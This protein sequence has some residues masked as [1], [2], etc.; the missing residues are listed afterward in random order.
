MQFWNF[1][2]YFT[3]MEAMLD[4]LTYDTI[5]YLYL[6]YSQD[7]LTSAVEYNRTLAPCTG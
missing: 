5:F 1:L 4:R 6:I 2:L 3:N 7:D